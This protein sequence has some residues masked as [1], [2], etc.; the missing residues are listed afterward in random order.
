MR[1]PQHNVTETYI[2]LLGRIFVE[3]E[4]QRMDKRNGTTQSV[5]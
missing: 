5:A 2:E 4:A 1:T 3:R